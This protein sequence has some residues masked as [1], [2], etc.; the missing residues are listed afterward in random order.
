MKRFLLALAAVMMLVMPA[1]AAMTEFT[2]IKLDVPSGWTSEEDL[3]VVALYAPDYEAALSI[4]YD[5]TDG[6]S[7]LE[8][9]SAM[10][11]V[12]KG[13]PPTADEHGNFVFTFDQDDVTSKSILTVYGPKY[14]MFTITD[15]FN[16]YSD[17]IL[18]CIASTEAK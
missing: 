13:T 16:K 1:Q 4:A 10:S 8:L 2:H 6:L 17:V 12:L 18:K 14:A 9:A 3:P 5:T 15:P 11:A 7:G